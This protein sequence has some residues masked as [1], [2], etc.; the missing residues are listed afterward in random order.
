MANAFAITITAVDKAT[1]TVKKVNESFGKLTRPISDMR[2]SVAAFSKEAG[3][4]R[5]GKSLVNVGRA[6]GDVGEKIASIGAPLAAVFGVSSLA[7]VGELATEW[8]KLGAEI[9]RTSQTIGIST[10]ALQTLRGAARI[11]GVSAEDLTGGLK[12]LGDTMQDALYGR[13][14]QALV[15]MNRLGIRLHRTADGAVD[16]SRAFHDLAG[17]ISRV[18]NPQVQ[19]LIAR[20]FGLEAALPLL[21][22]GREGVAELERQVARSGSVMSGPAVASAAAFQRSFEY[23]GL[24]VDGVRNSIGEKLLPVLSP[25]ITKFAEWLTVN[26]EWIAL[27]VGQAAKGFADALNG[28]DWKAVGAGLVS[29]GQG[30]KSVVDWLGGWKNAAELLL[31]F[32]AGK[33]LLGMLASIAQVSAA[34]TPVLARAAALGIGA[35]GAAGAGIATATGVGAV[36]A[37]AGLVAAPAA[38]IGLAGLYGYEHRNDSGADIA[39]RMGL[40]ADVGMGGAG[41]GV[42]VPGIGGR[43]AEAGAGGDSK[44]TI[45]IETPHGTTATKR[46]DGPPIADVQTGQSMP[47]TGP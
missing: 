12:T 19:G 1:A 36:V 22:Q 27:N 26:R 6:A 23:L 42:P 35:V 46:W 47:G 7:A 17:A 30:I 15:I 24:A 44:L 11:A 31:A 18:K 33:W 10:T 3:I 43:G 5:L 32:M 21:R 20:T 37:G 13:N 29:I 39:K 4:D 16:T 14:Q 9:S 41:Q 45:T 25:I 2:K 34:L 38:A 40:D 28:V 8:A